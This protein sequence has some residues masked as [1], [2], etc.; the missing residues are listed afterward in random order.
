MYDVLLFKAEFADT[1]MIKNFLCGQQLYSEKRTV[2]LQ[3]AKQTDFISQ[4]TLEKM[5]MHSR[6]V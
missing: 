4:A 1:F 6:L 3:M 5:S 2:H